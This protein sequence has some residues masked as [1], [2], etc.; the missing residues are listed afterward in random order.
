MDAEQALE[1]LDQ[2]AYRLVRGY[3][4]RESIAYV[5]RLLDTGEVRIIGPS[6]PADVVTDLFGRAA[7]G[8]ADSDADKAG[9]V[10]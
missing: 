8:Y 7:Q 9:S 3:A 10:N 4:N 6:L 1:L 2:A 5:V